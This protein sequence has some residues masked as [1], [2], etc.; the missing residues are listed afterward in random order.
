MSQSKDY[1]GCKGRGAQEEKKERVLVT[2]QQ[3]VDL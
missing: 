3:H 1:K 2:Q